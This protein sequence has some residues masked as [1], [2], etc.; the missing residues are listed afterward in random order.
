MKEMGIDTEN[1]AVLAAGDALSFG[2]NLPADR[3]LRKINNLRAAYDKENETW[4]R[5]ALSLGW[6]KWDVGIP[7]ESAKNKKA[8]VVMPSNKPKRRRTNK[9]RTPI[10]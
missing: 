4:Q 8:K 9:N 6:S 10:N 2:L 7:F 3:A 1:P 5:I